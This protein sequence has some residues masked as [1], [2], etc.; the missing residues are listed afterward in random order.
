MPLRELATAEAGTGPST[1][2]R[3]N[4]VREVR[5]SANPDGR[6]LGEIAADITGRAGRR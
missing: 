3:K 6:S 4:L 2:R 5:V 1:I